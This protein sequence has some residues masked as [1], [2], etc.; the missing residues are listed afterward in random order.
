MLIKGGGNGSHNGLSYHKEYEINE[1][2]NRMKQWKREKRILAF[3]LSFALVAGTFF[4]ALP[5][6]VFAAAKE[7]V[8]VEESGLTLTG[9]SLTNPDGN[10]LRCEFMNLAGTD[11]G[12]AFFLQP[13][14]DKHY[15]SFDF[16]SPGKGTDVYKRQRWYS[17]PFWIF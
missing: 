12:R 3:F 1:G 13:Y 2:G 14:A 10:S 6:N 8:I 4:G 16:A 11:N 5:A 9:T 17:L 15:V 7:G